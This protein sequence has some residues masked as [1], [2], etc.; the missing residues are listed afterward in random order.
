M[1]VLHKVSKCSVEKIKKKQD[2]NYIPQV[3]NCVLEAMEENINVMK[4]H[5]FHE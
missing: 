1:T 3:S 5:S 4:A 2:N